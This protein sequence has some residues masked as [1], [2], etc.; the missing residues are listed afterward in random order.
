MFP[1]ANL[2]K[3]LERAR[4][5]QE[6]AAS[7]KIK[8]ERRLQEHQALQSDSADNKSS[9]AFSDLE[10]CQLKQEIEVR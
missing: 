8:L 2:Q 5:E 10:V 6:T 1:P 9:A 3:E 7:E 4:Q